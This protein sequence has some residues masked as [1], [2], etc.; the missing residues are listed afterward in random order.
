M[1]DLTVL[2]GSEEALRCADYTRGL[3]VDPGGTAI[4]ADVIIGIDVPLPWPKPVFD[5][6]LLQGVGQFVE[7]A[8]RRTRVLAAVPTNSDQFSIVRYERTASGTSRTEWIGDSPEIVAADLPA[9]IAGS[10]PSAAMA[11]STEAPEVWICTQGSHDMCCGSD[12]TR[13]A[14]D[15]SEGWPHMKI[16]RVSHTGGH[17]FAPTALTMPSGRMWAYLDPVGLSDI[18]TRGGDPASLAERCRGWWGAAPGAA[19]FAERAL[20]GIHGWA[21][22]EAGRSIQ[23]LEADELGAGLERFRIKVEGA[24][25]V[26][27]VAD[28]AVARELPTIACHTPGG[29]PY[30][31]A[32]EYELASFDRE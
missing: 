32:Y 19:Q 16:R 4:H 30:K 26:T 22:D 1:I 29:Q 9:V 10:E 25:P 8:P 11:D 17:R 15:L 27:Y 12:G 3:A 6:V 28:V 2:P 5:H 13:L 18:I 31:R 21:I 7:A 24:T 14:N 23:K 20:L